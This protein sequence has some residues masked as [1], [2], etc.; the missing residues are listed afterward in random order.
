MLTHYVNTAI[1]SQLAKM[2][3]LQLEIA[4]C[5]ISAE[6]HPTHEFARRHGTATS[7]TSNKFS[8]RVSGN[9]DTRILSEPPQRPATTPAR[10]SSAPRYGLRCRA[11]GAPPPTPRNGNRTRSTERR[12]TEPCN[13]T[14]IAKNAGQPRADRKPRR[15]ELRVRTTEQVNDSESKHRASN[16]GKLILTFAFASEV[17]E[18]R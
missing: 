9:E 16:C 11:A 14:I 17:A 13:N 6:L 10:R 3:P 18:P 15:V 1:R 5:S 12:V 4:L 7:K 8:P 2:C